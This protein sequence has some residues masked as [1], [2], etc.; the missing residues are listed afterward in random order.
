MCPLIVLVKFNSLYS[1]KPTYARNGPAQ[2]GV[3]LCFTFSLANIVM[4]QVGA[5]RQD[6]SSNEPDSGS[7]AGGA[8]RVQIEFILESC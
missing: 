6:V 1:N 2:R 8:T 4:S 7:T 3:F 5:T